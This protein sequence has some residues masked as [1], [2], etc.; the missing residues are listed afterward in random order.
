MTYKRLTLKDLTADQ[1]RQ[2]NDAISAACRAHGVALAHELPEAV[3]QQL[4]RCTMD[5]F[6]AENA[7]AALAEEKARSSA[8]LA[9]EIKTFTWGAGRRRR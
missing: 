2:L 3:R 1:R 6:S 5:R 9:T 8:L 7:A 4:T